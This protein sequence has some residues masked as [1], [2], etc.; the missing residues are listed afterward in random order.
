MKEGEGMYATE[1]DLER[2]KTKQHAIEHVV[3]GN[4]ELAIGL[5]TK[6]MKGKNEQNT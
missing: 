4:Y 2:M 1:E 6:L 3:L 5:L